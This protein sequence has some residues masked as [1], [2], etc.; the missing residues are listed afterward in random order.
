MIIMEWYDMIR[1]IRASFFEDYWS[2][3]TN[4]PELLLKLKC[5]SLVLN[6]TVS[7]FLLIGLGVKLVLILFISFYGCTFGVNMSTGM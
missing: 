2:T 5:W 7:M 1:V 3:W 6:Y 4:L